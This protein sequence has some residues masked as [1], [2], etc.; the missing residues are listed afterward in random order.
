MTQWAP[1]ATRA[2]IWAE[3]V[4]ASR[5]SSAKNVTNASRPL[6]DFLPK[7][8]SVRTKITSMNELYRYTPALMTLRI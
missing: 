6:G 1:T 3:T 4:F 5:T 8:A 7:D 2:P